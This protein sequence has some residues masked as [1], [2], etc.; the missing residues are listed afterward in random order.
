MPVEIDGEQIANWTP[1]IIRGGT[2][3]VPISFLD[4]AGTP[5]SLLSA[6]IIITPN[7]SAGISWTQGNGLFPNLAIGEYTTDLDEAYTSALAWD[8]GRYRIQIVDGS[9]NTTPCI[10]EG[11]IFV[12]DC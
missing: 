8:S 9:G 12:R 7:S 5:Q 2:F 1:V 10:T 3:L 11:L 6:S 4:S